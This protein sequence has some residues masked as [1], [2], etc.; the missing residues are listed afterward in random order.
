MKQI[1]ALLNKADSLAIKEVER[2][3]RAV[4][5]RNNKA[6]KFMMAMGTYFFID[7]DGEILSDHEI[8]CKALDNFI[9][10]YDSLKLT[11]EAMTFTANGKI[12][13]HW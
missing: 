12:I 7:K 5:S 3:A 6:Q 11:G 4:L 10:K 9:M 1:D 8:N 2:R 13:K